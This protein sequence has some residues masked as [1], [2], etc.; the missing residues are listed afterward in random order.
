MSKRSKLSPFTEVGTSK[1]IILPGT[2]LQEA[3]IKFT[4]DYV[5]LAVG[6]QRVVQ[7][8]EVNERPDLSLIQIQ[9]TFTVTVDSLNS[10]LLGPE[11]EQV[12]IEN[13]EVLQ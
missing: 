2:A 12:P 13:G 6:A 4:L 3:L 5:P 11:Q 7:I 8:G 10:M 9:D 1:Q